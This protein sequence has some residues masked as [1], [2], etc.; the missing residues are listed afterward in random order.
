L[1]SVN[2][3]PLDKLRARGVLDYCERLGIRTNCFFIIGFPAD[4]YES[5]RKT[6]ATA[7]W[8][9]PNV[10]EF[11]IAAPHPGTSFVQANTTMDNIT[12]DRLCFDHPNCTEAGLLLMRKK[13]YRQFY[14]RPA[15]WWKNLKMLVQ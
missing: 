2:R 14:T 7:I 10:A 11:F 8:L 9:N 4:T 15:A 5:I 12:A 6:I 1:K 13:A 3:A